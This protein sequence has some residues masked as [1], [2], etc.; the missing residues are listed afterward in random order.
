MLPQQYKTKSD[1][2]NMSYADLHHVIIRNVKD[3]PQKVAGDHQKQQIG[4]KAIDEEEL[5]KYMSKLPSYLERGENLQERVLNVGVL[6]WGRLEK[7]QYSH[8]QT[9]YRDS[10]YSTSSS[11][12][13]SSF[14]TDESPTDSSRGHSCSPAHQRMHRPSLQFHLTTSPME[15]HSQDVKFFEESVGKVQ[16][17]K[18][19]ESNTFNGQEKFF[20]TAPAFCKNHTDVKVEQCKKND[21]EPKSG[22]GTGT[23]KN[24]PSDEM[25]SCRKVKIKSQD[26]EFTKREE[27]LQK[28]KFKNSK[29]DVPEGC[30]TV[31][32]LLPR[33]RME[34]SHSG[35]SHN[36]NS[37]T[38]CGRRSAEACR[39][40]FSDK[41][42]HAD[43]N[44]DIPRS[45][46]HP[47]EVSSKE[48]QVKVK[49]PSYEDTVSIKFS[50]GSSHSTLQSAKVAKN[51]SKD[52]ILEEKSSTTVPTCLPRNETS[53]AL[54]PKPCKAEKVRSTS[55]FRRL[56]N[57]VGKMNKSSD[58]HNLKSTNVSA[59]ACSENAMAS[60]GMDASSSDQPTATGRARSSP[61]RR[62][63]EPLLKPKAENCS[64]LVDPSERR[65][66]STE[67]ACRSSDGHLGSFVVQSGK[68]K[69][70]M[71]GCKTININDS[72]MDK[73]HGP[74]TTF[75]ALLRVAVKNGLPLLTFAVDK[76]R[77]IIAATL[78]KLNTTVMDDYSCIYTF[79]TIREVK[80]KNGS[81][82]NQGGK[83][84]AHDYIR[85]V[86]AQMKVSDSQMSNLIPQ[87]QFSMREFVLFSV[88]L[89]QADNQTSV[90]QPNDE[91]AAIVVKIPKKI[92]P[93]SRKHEHE[94]NNGSNMSQVSLKESLSGV[95]CKSNLGENVQ[96]Q[97]SLSIQNFVST[98]V[99]LPGGTHSLPS[100]GG[101]SSLIER[102]NT[103]GSCD[104]GGWDL[105]C[106]LRILANRNQAPE[107][108][109]STNCSP[110][111]DRL[112]LFPEVLVFNLNQ[113]N[114]PQYYI[115]SCLLMLLLA[116][117]TCQQGGAQ[118]KPLFSLAPFKDGVYSVE[119]SS[120]LSTLQAFS[121]CIAVLD[122]RNLRELSEPCNSL[123][124]KTFGQTMHAVQNSGVSGTSR[125]EGDVPRYV[126]YPPLSPVGRV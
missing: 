84:K 24:V 46:P 82:I 122:N 54:D 76:E 112:E 67:R 116:F 35:V 3:S 73:K 88:D 77:D 125:T 72:A 106:K 94:N 123:E 43:M 119:F 36:S 48:S 96:S 5:V 60:S 98:A 8:K 56:N 59:K 4:G 74:L 23:L 81:W 17:I 28:P 66:V 65:S 11:N 53:K 15:G 52:R 110:T 68:V 80:K 87:N 99:I 2:P 62:L 107:K 1:K 121:I 100:K 19:S 89:R 38:F 57:G 95:S 91:L 22:S 31:V 16:D 33:G 32:L 64:R 25:A 118:S 12:T 26:G 104:C 103:G 126:S 101:P 29:E 14:S 9:Q 71:I 63:L 93:S 7:W 47:Q 61:L 58:I 90:F 109:S 86:V 117:N 21:T 79:F 102:W 85:N 124:E 113:H 49:Q 41:S 13:S 50:S 51:L 30:R 42:V 114:D 34:S 40:S 105:G 27:N 44:S 69:L 115:G 78:K 39:R 55:P 92:I 111:T 83:G 75:Q 20:S 45:C 108:S 97:H 70:D 6:D 10:R 18:T 120:P 37:A